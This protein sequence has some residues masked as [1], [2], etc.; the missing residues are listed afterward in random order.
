MTA[1]RVRDFVIYT[2]IGLLVGL[3]IMW[4]AFHTDRPVEAR[5]F[6]WLGLA[7]N[8]MIVFGYAIKE[9][10][11][12]WKRRSFWGVLSLLLFVHLFVFVA[13]LRQI[14]ELR[15]FWWGVI[16]IMEYFA[17]LVA[18]GYWLGKSAER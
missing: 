1:N 16:T 4:L 7:V 12:L 17:I 3:S 2:A 18:T 13:F 11:I 9:N 8:T 6:K 14:D 15:V 5:I 10:R